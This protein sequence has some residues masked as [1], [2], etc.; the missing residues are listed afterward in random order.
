MV[1]SVNAACSSHAYRYPMQRKL[2]L[3]TGKTVWLAYRAP[4]VPADNLTRDIQCDVLVVGMGISG[5]MIAEALTAAGHSVVAV[6][7]RRPMAGSTS[8]TTALV[9]YEIDQPLTVLTR[10][11]GA[12][13]AR[14]AW[15]RSRLAVSNLHGR[16]ADLELN[17]RAGLRPSLYLAGN[18]MTPSDLKAESAARRAIGINCRYLT[19]S[20][21]MDEFGIDREAAILSQG[22]IALDPRKLTAGMLLHARE[23][24]ARLYQHVEVTD[25]ESGSGGVTAQTSSGAV[26]RSRYLVLA[27]GYELLDMVPLKKHRI[28]STW[29][30][31]TR[32]Q[33]KA[34]W[35]RQ[36]FIWEASD[37]YLYLRAT[38]DGRVI[39]GGEDEEFADEDK[40]DALMSRKVEAIRKKLSQLLPHIDT[41]PDHA[42]AGS[43]GATDTGLPYIGAIPHHPRMLAV[44]GYGGNGITYSQ[45]ASEIITTT[46]AGKADAD[47]DLFAFDP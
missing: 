21:V 22:N 25:I 31:A 23:R 16:I 7:R 45:L 37:P 4:S 38:H 33:P 40:R 35:P 14:R 20:A 17:C 15:R 13:K 32:P 34:I 44:M 30:M 36:A 6:D 46:L 43:F 12:D 11:V 1:Q 29:A 18:A 47:A 26:I 27:T 42:W 28:I 41:T 8:A 5:A 10:Q 39:C 19:R 24:G 3:R 2:D 9:Q